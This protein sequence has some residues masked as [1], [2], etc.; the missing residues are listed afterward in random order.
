MALFNQVNA[1]K[2]AG[3]TTGEEAFPAHFRGSD[4]RYPL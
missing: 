1:R 2:R 4:Q 3:N